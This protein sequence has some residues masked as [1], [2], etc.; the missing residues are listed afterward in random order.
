MRCVLDTD[1]I[2]AGLRSAQG[3]SRQIIRMAGRGEITVIATATMM[4]EYEEVLKR[5][6]HLK[7]V[8]LTAMQVD[9]LLDAFA[10]LFEPVTPHFLWR[11]LLKDPDDE[12]ILE[13][14]VNGQAAVII[15]FNTRHY[16]PAAGRF[17]IDILRPGSFLRRF[18]A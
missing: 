16:S 7:A 4:V 3:A 18:N 2:I 13:A 8:N 10:A 9:I 12:M 17:G 11:P 15:T 14:A 1:V 6:Q 5:P